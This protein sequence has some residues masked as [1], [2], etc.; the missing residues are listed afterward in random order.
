MSK[1]KE[2]QRTVRVTCSNC[3]KTS[4]LPITEDKG[5][6]WLVSNARCSYCNKL[7]KDND[8]GSLWFM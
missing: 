2:K 4:E 8:K 1:T 7:F 3:N 5:L 6:V